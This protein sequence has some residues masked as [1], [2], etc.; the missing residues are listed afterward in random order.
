MLRSYFPIYQIALDLEGLRSPAELLKGAKVLP[1][2]DAE[3][4]VLL[5]TIERECL[6]HGL[7]HTS[8]L[9]KRVISRPSPGT[10][11]HMFSELNHLNDS[12]ISELRKE[13]I[14]HIP[15]S[16]RITLSVMIFSVRK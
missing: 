9:A 16:G 13:L 6:D 12:L 11:D 2:R 14:F 8:E 1:P 10:Y 7:T 3:F 4:R 5:E 15:P